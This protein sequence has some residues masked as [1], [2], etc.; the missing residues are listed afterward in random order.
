MN[1]VVL[2]DIDE[3]LL[4]CDVEINVNGSKKVF[5]QV[6]G[7]DAHQD[8]IFNAGKTEKCVIEEVVKL[9]KK[10][11]EDQDIE[12]PNIAYKIWA[13]STEEEL[14]SQPPIIL[15]GVIN[16]LEELSKDSKIVTG[17]LTGN[18]RLRAAAK[19]KAAKLAKYFLD[20]NRVLRGAFGDVSNKRIDLIPEAKEKFGQGVYIIVDDSLV[21]AKMTKD[22]SIPAI[23][24][25]T[26]QASMEEL[27]QY[28]KFVFSDFGENRWKDVIKIIESYE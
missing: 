17:L 16:L 11:P 12:I 9:V 23:L 2:F 24:V 3:T 20:K 21:A 10:Y 25:A 1:K 5:K 7:I 27:R 28:S 13:Q 4:S 15:P 26:G 22:A 6:F 14:K 18:S 8:M 19:M